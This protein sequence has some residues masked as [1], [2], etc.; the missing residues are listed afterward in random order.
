MVGF[1]NIAVFILATTRT[2]GRY[3]QEYPTY[4]E[5]RIVPIRE[6]WGQYFHQLYFVFGTNKFDHS[7][8]T[9][10]CRS[11]SSVSGGAGRRL[12]GNKD[13]VPLED[14]RELYSCPIYELDAHYHSWGGGTNETLRSPTANKQNAMLYDF[15]ALWTGNCT[16]EYFGM[17]PTCRCQEAMRYFL[18]EPSMQH[19]EWFI[20]IDD[21]ILFRPYSLLSMLN[22][23]TKTGG[24][25]VLKV[26]AATDGNRIALVGPTKYRGFD[27]SK[28]TQ[29]DD[30]PELHRCKNSTAYEFA[31][32]QPAIIN[33]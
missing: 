24:P 32:A 7:F 22:E 30:S 28:K 23:L 5:S 20:F 4:F 12:A 21:D 14:T 31:F 9:Q 26:T 29:R 6:T 3:K 8:L 17:G 2:N 10:Q 18:H 16:G 11:Q 25:P 15:N 33:R 1:D 19:N 27:F 13:Q